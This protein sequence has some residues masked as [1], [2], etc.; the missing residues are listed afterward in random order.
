MP[1]LTDVIVDGVFLTECRTFYTKRETAGENVL[2][3]QLKS[4]TIRVSTDSTVFR[5]DV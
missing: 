5:V 3:L 2:P 1:D 4:H